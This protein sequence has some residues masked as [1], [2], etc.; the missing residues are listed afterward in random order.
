MC[1][2]EVLFVIV[3]GCDG[4]CVC[5]CVSEMG[6]SACPGSYDLVCT[7][8]SEAARLWSCFDDHVWLCVSGYWC[9][10]QTLLMPLRRRAIP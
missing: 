7:A 1:L 4:L 8:L 5:G 2:N 9:S 6:M 10:L 3:S